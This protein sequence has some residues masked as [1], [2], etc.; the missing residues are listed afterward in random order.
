MAEDDHQ[1]GLL[2]AHFE[3]AQKEIQT[4]SNYADLVQKKREMRFAYQKH[5]AEQ[6]EARK[7]AKELQ[8]EIDAVLLMT[9]W[10]GLEGFSH[11]TVTRIWS[12]TIKAVKWLGMEIG[13]DIARS[14]WRAARANARDDASA[15]LIRNVLIALDE[16]GEQ[17]V[18]ELTKT[19][20]TK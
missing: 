14:V 19:E 18:S 15:G 17:R 11:G 2:K 9:M 20:G 1:V 13:D 8:R 16:A 5:I 6:Q 4:A 3:I 10:P 12:A 7:R